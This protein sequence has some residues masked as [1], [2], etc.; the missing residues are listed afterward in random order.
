M[1][2]LW[3]MSFHHVNAF[4][5]A[6]DAYATP[7]TQCP[8]SPVCSNPCDSLLWHLTFGPGCSS[9]FRGCEHQNLMSASGSPVYYAVG[10]HTCRI[11]VD[12]AMKLETGVEG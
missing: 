8:R 9:G 5:L 6:R 3:W 4:S 12:G 2:I 1:K 10:F 7:K 11:F